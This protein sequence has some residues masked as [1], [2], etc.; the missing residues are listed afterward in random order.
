MFEISGPGVYRRR[1]GDEIEILCDGNDSWVKKG[2]ICT[3]DR[4]KMAYYDSFY[5]NGQVE[6]SDHTPFDLVEC[7]KLISMP[8]DVATEDQ[9][10]G[11]AMSEVSPSGTVELA[12]ERIGRRVAYKIVVNGLDDMS[13][14]DAVQFAIQTCGIPAVVQALALDTCPKAGFQKLFADAMGQVVKR[15]ICSA[16]DVQVTFL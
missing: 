1:N 14:E 4:T 12:G 6:M 5:K 9:N 11:D 7:V 16:A 15:R 13:I 3:I 2:S 8:P 10:G